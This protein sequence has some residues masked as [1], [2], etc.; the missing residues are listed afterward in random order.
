M[1]SHE[2]LEDVAV[3]EKALKGRRQKHCLWCWQ[4]KK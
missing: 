3:V 2:E 1:T 4:Q